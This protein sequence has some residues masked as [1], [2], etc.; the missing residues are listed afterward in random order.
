MGEGKVGENLSE[1]IFWLWER[2]EWQE[3]L[4]PGRLYIG[5]GSET[6]TPPP[7]LRFFR[8]ITP[9]RRRFAALLPGSREGGGDLGEVYKV[10]AALQGKASDNAA[11]FTNGTKWASTWP[12]SP[13]R[14]K[15]RDTPR[16]PRAHTCARPTTLRLGKGCGN[17]A[18]PETQK[19]YA[20]AV[21]LFKKG[22]PDVSLPSIEAVEVPFEGGKS[23]PAYFVKRRDMKSHR[24]PTVVF[25]D[26]LDSTKEFAV[27]SGPRR[28]WRNAA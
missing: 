24:L 4:W 18:L 7:T 1:G 15:P 14:Q 5:A 9:G 3:P 20:R 16:P 19:A 13:A 23:L 22:I 26:G 10:C 27:S 25:F 8:G 12:S 28:I 21:E 11:W 2:R 6:K 17:H